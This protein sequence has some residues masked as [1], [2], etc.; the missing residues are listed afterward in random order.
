MTNRTSLNGV[1]QAEW[2]MLSRSVNAGF[3]RRWD[4]HDPGGPERSGTRTS[5]TLRQPAQSRQPTQSRRPQQAA[6]R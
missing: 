5:R 3:L 2:E 6:V 1:R 4:L